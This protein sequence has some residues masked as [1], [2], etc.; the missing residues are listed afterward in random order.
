MVGIWLKFLLVNINLY[1]GCPKTTT[2]TRMYSSRMC[3]HPALD[4]GGGLCPGGFPDR[5][6]LDRA[7]WTESPWTETPRQRPHGRNMGLGNQSGSDIIQ[8]P[9]LWTEW[10]IHSCENITLPQTSFAGGNNKDWAL[11][12]LGVDFTGWLSSIFIVNTPPPGLFFSLSLYQ[13]CLPSFV[14]QCTAFNFT[15]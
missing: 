2:A 15:L 10:L 11:M 12:N 14:Y 7:P 9:P 4:H 13:S 8:R 5:D 6:P 3:T 1:E